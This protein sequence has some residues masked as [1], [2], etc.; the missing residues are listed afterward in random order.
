MQESYDDDAGYGSE[1]ESYDGRNPAY[2]VE[3]DVGAAAPQDLEHIKPENV[4]GTQMKRVVLAIRA[5]PYQ[6]ARNKALCEAKLSEKMQKELHQVVS[7]N[8]RHAPTTEDLAGDLDQI[9][10]TGLEAVSYVNGAHQPVKAD[11]ETQ[12][13]NT[14]TND[15]RAGILLE[16]T[17]GNVHADKQNVL[18]P[19]NIM[20]RDMLEI[21]E[22]CDDTVLA[23]EFQTLDDIKSGEKQC[24]VYTEGAAA[25]LLS[26]CPDMFDNYCI[27]QVLPGT[28]M[29][30]VPAKTSKK[31]YDYMKNTIDSI[32]GSFISA[33]D[34]RVR[35]RPEMGKWDDVQ[36]YIGNQSILST[37]KQL[38]YNNKI[39][40][41]PVRIAVHFDMKY[42][43]VPK[44]FK[45]E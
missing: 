42:I 41:T 30:I 38:E 9:I 40:H 31:L 33:K 45:K 32:R 24:L 2:A 10:V 11:I 28:K 13:P 27:T 39:L 22:C 34:I 16:C 36:N 17:K 14:L 7:I 23:K 12:V 1:N 19:K 26:S 25:N 4:Y 35:F 20:A 37:D 6:L 18:S 43:T 44:I 21:W 8:N 29:A 5:S 3:Q 15:D